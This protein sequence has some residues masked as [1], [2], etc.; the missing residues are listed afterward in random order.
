MAQWDEGRAG[1]R[2]GYSGNGGSH[3]AGEGVLSDEKRAQLEQTLENARVELDRY[4]DQAAAFIRERPVACL[5][6]ALAL[7]FLVGKIASRR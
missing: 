5:A 1:D 4:V 6:G 3:P 7:G 2:P